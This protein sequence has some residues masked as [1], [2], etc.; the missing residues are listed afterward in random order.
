MAQVLIL[1]GLA[2]FSAAVISLWKVT[3]FN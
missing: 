3:R 2:L 1:T